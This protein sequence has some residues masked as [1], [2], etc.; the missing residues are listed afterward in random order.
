MRA[1]LAVAAVTG[2]LV[3]LVTDACGGREENDHARMVVL[4]R[5]LP[6]VVVGSPPPRTIFGRGIVLINSRRLLQGTMTR[7]KFA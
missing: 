2:I 3:M 4:S 6:G 7:P 1:W 5:G